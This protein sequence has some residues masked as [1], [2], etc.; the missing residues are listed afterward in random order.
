MVSRHQV[1]E[2]RGVQSSSKDISRRS[3]KCRTVQLSCCGCPRFCA[4][5]ANQEV[6]C[7]QTIRFPRRSKSGSALWRGS[8]RKCKVGSTLRS[9]RR[10][11]VCAKTH[12]IMQGPCNK[13]PGGWRHRA[14]KE[15]LTPMQK[16]SSAPDADKHESTSN[17]PRSDLRV[18]IAASE[19]SSAPGDMGTTVRGSL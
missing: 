5:Q 11:A 9:R 19:H 18:R 1:C 2:F 10:V 3:V 13:K 8:H 15:S 12:L 16:L 17:P 14:Q 4:V 7:T 6:H